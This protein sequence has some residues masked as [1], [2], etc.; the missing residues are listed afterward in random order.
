M[1]NSTWPLSSVDPSV[2]STTCV[3]CLSWGTYR[4][5]KTKRDH[6]EDIVRAEELVEYIVI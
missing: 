6:Q 4:S 1:T 2:E 5:R 3:S